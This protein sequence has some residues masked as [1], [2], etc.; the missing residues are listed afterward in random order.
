MRIRRFDNYRL[1]FRRHSL[2][3]RGLQGTGAFRPLAHNLD[4]IHNVLWL[5]EIGISQRRGPGKIFIHIGQHRRKLRERFHARI[6]GLLIHFGG[7]LMVFQGGVLLQPAVRLDNF[8]GISGCGQN[9]RDQFVG[10]QRDRRY[11]LLQLF[12]IHLRRLDCRLALVLSILSRY[13]SLQLLVT[14]I[15]AHAKADTKNR[16]GII[17]SNIMTC[18]LAGRRFSLMLPS[19]LTVSEPYRLPK[20]IAP[21]FPSAPI[22][23]VLF[24]ADGV[25]VSLLHVVKHEIGNTL[26]V[27]FG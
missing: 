2:L 26:I 10:I 27:Q 5:V 12:C 23:Q 9:F 7:Q 8:G 1:P 17:L 16:L 21:H 4:S 11:Q 19:R 13:G 3:C 18:L 6:P 24:T 25:E 14:K 15:S 20:V 22:G